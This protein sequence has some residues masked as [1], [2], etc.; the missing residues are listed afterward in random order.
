MSEQPTD[1]PKTFTQEDLDRILGER[2]AVAQRKAKQE[3]DAELAAK[4]N[5]ASLDELLE[6]RQKVTEAENAAK[7]EAQRLRDEAAA[8]KAAAE[9]ERQAAKLELHTARLHKALTAAGVPEDAIDTIRVDVEVGATPEDIKAAVD[10][11]KVKVPALF[12]AKPAPKVDP[13]D[14][15]PP[16]QDTEFGAEGAAEFEARYPHLVQKPA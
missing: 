4:L 2:L 12:G 3:A 15:T 7:T 6:A 14:P 16:R 10:A 5:G 11:L 9:A 1:T 8:E 13:G